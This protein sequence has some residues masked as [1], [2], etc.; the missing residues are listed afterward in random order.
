MSDQRE[1][2]EVV[3]TAILVREPGDKHPYDLDAGGIIMLASSV[4][5]E[6]YLMRS[7]RKCEHCGKQ[8]DSVTPRG[9]CV[10]HNRGAR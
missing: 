5:H 9:A 8:A 6:C 1:V 10:D 7:P 2:F 3:I 4:S